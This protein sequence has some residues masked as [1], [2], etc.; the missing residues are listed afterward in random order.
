MQ[1]LLKKELIKITVITLIVSIPLHTGQTA[2]FVR[3]NFPLEF[4]G[5]LTGFV[6]TM[7][8]VST[9]ILFAAP[10]V[11]NNYG[12]SVLFKMMFSAQTLTFAFPFVLLYRKLR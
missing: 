11:I 8:T 10:T 3:C 4:F 7:Y 5:L 6:R 9:S 2:L 1:W 12:M